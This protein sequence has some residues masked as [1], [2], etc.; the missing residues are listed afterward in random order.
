M[1]SWLRLALFSLVGIV[2]LNL[3]LNIFFGPIGYRAGYYGGYYG[4][5]SP[6]YRQMHG[7]MR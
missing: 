7:W 6:I 2:V 5:R 4:G 1:N 3:F